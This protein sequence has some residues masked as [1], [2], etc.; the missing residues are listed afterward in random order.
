M[1]R[2]V[3]RLRLATLHAGDTP[4]P[5]LNNKTPVVGR[6][7]ILCAAPCVCSALYVHR[8]VC[9]LRLATLD[10]GDTPAPPLN[11]KTRAVATDHLLCV[12]PCVCTAL[13]VHRLVFAPPCMPTTARYARCGGHPRTPPET[14]TLL[15]WPKTAFCVQ[16]LVG[17][18][19]CMCT[20]LCMHRLVCRLRLASLD[21]GDTPA[22]P[23]N[24]KTSAVATNRLL[25]AVPSLRTTLYVHRLVYALPCAT[26]LTSMRLGDIQRNNRNTPHFTLCTAIPLP[27]F[28][29]ATKRKW[30]RGSTLRPHSLL[31]GV[32]LA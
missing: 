8:L 16:R 21:A 14:T 32:P 25:C 22:P 2:L 28:H 10:A 7:P 30:S 20:A 1:H 12:A 11:N 4:A 18:P 3:C 17:V 27:G 31:S 24:S 23:L 9:A 13:Y 29:T 5:P 26:R 6:D 15:R 19:A